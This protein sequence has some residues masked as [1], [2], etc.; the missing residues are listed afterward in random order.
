MKIQGQR[1][2]GAE[3]GR[4]EEV[5]EIAGVE[6]PH[7]RLEPLGFTGAETPA[8]LKTLQPPWLERHATALVAAPAPCDHWGKAL[9][10]KA[11]HPRT[12]RPL[13]GTITLTSPRLYPCRGPR[14]QTP[15]VRPLSALLTDAVAP[16]RLVRATTGAA[17]VSYG[18]TAPALQDVRPGEATRKATPIQ[19]PALAV[20]PGGEDARGEE[21]G[22]V[23]EGGPADGETLPLPAGPLTVG[24]DGG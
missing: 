22:A 7:Q 9:G 18:L 24:S 3:D 4:A 5:Q 1:V 23:V 15:T 8:I 16:E 21:P 20:A 6:K 13:L 17:L 14:R 12:F 10:I 11:S 19:T 2:L